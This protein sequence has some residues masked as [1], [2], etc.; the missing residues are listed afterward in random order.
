MLALQ[1]RNMD[2]CRSSASA[3]R[4]V[5]PAAYLPPQGTSSARTHLQQARRWECGQLLA[6][7]ES[8]CSCTALTA[9]RPI[10]DPDGVGLLKYWRRRQRGISLFAPLPPISN[11]LE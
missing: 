9:L 5:T 2:L 8:D 3:R 10:R 4:R 1:Q 11:F 7:P 6:Q